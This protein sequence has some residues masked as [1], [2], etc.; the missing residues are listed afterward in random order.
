MY[1]SVYQSGKRSLLYSFELNIPVYRL[2]LVRELDITGGD[3]G[4]VGYYAG[5]IVSDLLLKSFLRSH[6]DSIAM[7]VSLFFATESITVMWWSRLSDHIGRKPVLLT[8]LFGLCISMIFFGLSKTFWA[9]VVR[10]ATCVNNN[11]NST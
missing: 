8:G 1:P 7:Q 3:E 2:Q 4:K 5:L 6:S 11:E 9:V 10:Y